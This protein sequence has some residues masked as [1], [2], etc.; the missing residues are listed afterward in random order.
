MRKTNKIAAKLVNQ[1]LKIK[2]DV[3]LKMFQ[4]G[5]HI[6]GSI[7]SLLAKH[8]MEKQKGRNFSGT[9]LVIKSK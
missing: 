7:V 6:E 2:I 1:K 8:C 4:G 5:R 3:N 9:S